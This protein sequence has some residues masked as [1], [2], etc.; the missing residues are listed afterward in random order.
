MRISPASLGL[1]AVVSCLCAVPAF[2]GQSP[3]DPA[4]T[5]FMTFSHG[6]GPADD[7]AGAGSV[8]CRHGAQE[9]FLAT[10]A[11]SLAATA[12]VSLLWL[13]I[14]YSLAFRGAGALI[15]DFSADAASAG[16]GPKRSAAAPR[17]FRKCCSPPIR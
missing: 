3:I 4:D 1:A 2:A 13:I 11:Q 9:E 5:A 17:P 8:L 6:A 12:I 7:P 15:G 10:M 14:G 16:S